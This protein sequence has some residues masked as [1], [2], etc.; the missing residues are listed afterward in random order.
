M[1]TV[2]KS[3]KGLKD[4]EWKKRQLS[5]WPPIPY[6]PPTDLVTTKEVQESLKITLPNGTIFNKSIFSQGKTKEYLVHVI[7]VLC[8]INQKEKGLDV[9]CRKLAKAVDK[10][11][12]T[13]ENLQKT[14][15]T[16]GGT[17]RDELEFRKL[18]IGHT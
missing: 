12:G 3:L 17:P 15:G 7:A 6:V 18:E 1:S 4:S 5:S 11:A 8:L 16:K 14:V 10:L 13:L 2:L 9:Q